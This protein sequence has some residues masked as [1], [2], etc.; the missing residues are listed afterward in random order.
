[1]FWRN[2]TFLTFWEGVIP[3][4]YFLRIQL[5]FDLY[6]VLIDQGMANMPRNANRYNNPVALRPYQIDR[7]I[8]EAINGG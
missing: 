5:L 7:I 2:Q 6:A 4:G 1:V 8:P 3:L